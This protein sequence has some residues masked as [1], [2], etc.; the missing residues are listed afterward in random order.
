MQIIHSPKA[1]GKVC[2]LHKVVIKMVV[3]FKYLQGGNEAITKKTMNV[4]LS[5]VAN[6]NTL[7]IIREV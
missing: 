5:V 7:M 3:T 2:L 1:Q 4:L 6:R